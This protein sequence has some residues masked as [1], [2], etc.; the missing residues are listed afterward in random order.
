M[1]SP[2][3]LVSR[4]ALVGICM[5]LGAPFLR[6]QATGTQLV[7]REK[8]A[9]SERLLAAVVTSDWTSLDQDGRELLQLTMRPGWTALRLPEFARYSNDFARATRAVIDSAGRRDQR[10]A[11]EAYTDLVTSCVECHRYVARARQVHATGP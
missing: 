8:L 1:T 9:R 10:T 7:M 5:L 6:S 11:V 4:A 3:R 2:P